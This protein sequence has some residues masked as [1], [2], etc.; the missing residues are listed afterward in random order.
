MRKRVFRIFLC[1]VALFGLYSCGGGKNVSDTVST[2]VD[3]EAVDA[4]EAENNFVYNDSDTA[5]IA[6]MNLLSIIEGNDSRPGELYEAPN[7]LRYRVVKDGNGI[8]PQMGETAVY[9]IESRLPDGTVLES[10]LGGTP[11]EQK[12]NDTILPALRQGLQEMS[13]G[14]I[15]E[16]FIPDSLAG[17]HNSDILCAIQL[18]QIKK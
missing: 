15:Y 13:E 16:F 14:A 17:N 7:G 10:T 11:I 5:T 4:P 8:K 2:V 3:D 18:I 1:G 6:K 12:I 9:N